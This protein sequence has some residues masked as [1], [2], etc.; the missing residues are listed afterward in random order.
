MSSQRLNR[1]LENLGKAISQ[2]DEALQ[3]LETPIVRDASIQ[4]FELTYELLWKTV[5]NFKKRYMVFGLF[6]HVRY[7]RKHSHLT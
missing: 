5:K 6:R 1:N 2:L 3:E 7:S 4:R